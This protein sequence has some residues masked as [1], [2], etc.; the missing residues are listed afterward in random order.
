MLSH[1]LIHVFKNIDELVK[2]KFILCA[3]VATY[4]GDDIMPV[5]SEEGLSGLLNAKYA[6]AN[7][8]VIG[9]YCHVDDDSRANAMIADD[10]GRSILT[11]HTVQV[12]LHF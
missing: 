3:G 11:Q 1:L 9:N 12:T 8:N 7:Q 10:D 2:N 4:C 5:K 6:K